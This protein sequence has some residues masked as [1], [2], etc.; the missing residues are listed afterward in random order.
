[1]ASFN[2]VIMMGNLTRDPQLNYLP[3]QTPV[4]EFSLATSR[5]W[6]SK[7]GQQREEV[8]YVECKC[9]G[10]MA[11][12]I[13]Q[14]CTKG[15]PLMIEGRLS[16]DRWEGKD[17]EKRSKHYVTIESFTFVGSRNDGGAPQA[18]AAPATNVQ[19]T[20]S[21]APMGP[22]DIPFAPMGPDDIPF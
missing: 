2:K 3:N 1:M 9:F 5:K 22:D 8:C 13:N 6:N 19:M 21:A 16:F 12:T 17:G 4:V 15:R 18:A 11:E 20:P 10:K 7:E 14:Y